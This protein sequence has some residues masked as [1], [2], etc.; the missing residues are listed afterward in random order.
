MASKE[1]EFKDVVKPYFLF[2]K[3]DEFDAHWE[4]LDALALASESDRLDASQLL[5]LKSAKE[6]YAKWSWACP[7]ER[8]VK[9]D[10]SACCAAVD[11]W[12]AYR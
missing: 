1:L 8:T 6:W 5:K 7:S 3:C 11:R 4:E 12:A 2:D 9:S 10:V